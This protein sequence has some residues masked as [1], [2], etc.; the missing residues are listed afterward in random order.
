MFSP[1][2]IVGEGV[3]LSTQVCCAHMVKACSY[4]K[5][6]KNIKYMGNLPQEILIR[7]CMQFLKGGGREM[8]N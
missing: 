8:E 1:I 4:K 3:S 6:L 7:I 5:I 2:L